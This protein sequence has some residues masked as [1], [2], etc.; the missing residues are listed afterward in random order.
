[1]TRARVNLDSPSSANLA[2]EE[3]KSS[4]GIDR[5]FLSYFLWW[6]E[7]R[8]VLGAG[9]VYV[10]C[11]SEACNQ[12][13]QWRGYT[14]H[15][16]G[17]CLGIEIGILVQRMQLMVRWTLRVSPFFYPPLMGIRLRPFE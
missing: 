15:G 1:M 4:S 11:F 3:L 9:S 12:L 6:V 17:L 2:Q 8:Y 5:E 14:P 7:N 13:S 10:L 16:R